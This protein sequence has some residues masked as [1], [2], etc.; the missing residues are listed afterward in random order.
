MN[1][2]VLRQSG[3]S[4]QQWRDSPLGDPRDWPSALRLAASLVLESPAPM[5]LA[6]GGSLALLANDACGA[7]L[8][9]G[10]DRRP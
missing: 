10:A 3:I 6:W 1:T 2:A 4:E 5:W 9:A 8:P 7:L